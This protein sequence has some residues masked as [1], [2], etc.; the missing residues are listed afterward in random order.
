[1][2]VRWTHELGA[3]ANTTLWELVPAP[4][5]KMKSTVPPAATVT[6]LSDTSVLAASWNQYRTG[7]AASCATIPGRCGAT[8]GTTVGVVVGATVAVCVGVAVGVGVG[9]G[10]VAAG[11]TVT[12]PVIS[13]GCVEQ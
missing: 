12:V 13:A 10:S 7:F 1:M 9:V 3:L 2:P 4:C 8:V 5:G 6:E 11:T